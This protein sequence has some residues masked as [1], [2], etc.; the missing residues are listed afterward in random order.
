L[1]RYLFHFILV[2]KKKK[3]YIDDKCLICFY[4]TGCEFNEKEKKTREEKK[5]FQ[6]KNKHIIII[7]IIVY[8]R[9]GS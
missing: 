8:N 7:V 2:F 6:K 1:V 5:K 3:E 4:T 9:S